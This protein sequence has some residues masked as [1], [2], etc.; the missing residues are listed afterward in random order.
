M[1]SS[2]TINPA[3]QARIMAAMRQLL[4]ELP[5]EVAAPPEV[6]FKH[7]GVQPTMP[8]YVTKDDF[9]QVTIYT[10]QATTGLTL[11]ARILTPDG[12]VSYMGESLDNVST[13]TL[14]QKI[15]GLTEGFL[16]SVSVSNINGGLADQIC[17]VSVGLQF[18]SHAS[19]APHTMLCQGYVS[20]LYTIDWPPVYV[21]GPASSSTQ[22]TGVTPWS[23]VA[24]ANPTIA[25]IGLTT[26]YNQAASFSAAN[27]AQGILLT[28]TTSAAGNHLE[29]IVEAYP[30]PPFTTTAV[31]SLPP[32]SSGAEIGVCVLASL[33]AKAMTMS[34]N[35]NN[36]N[37][38]S[39]DTWSTPTTH[40]SSLFAG[41]GFGASLAGFRVQDDS[42]NIKFWF[43]SDGLVWTL[44]YS[45][46]K[47]AS[48]LGTGNFNYLGAYIDPQTGSATSAIVAWASTSP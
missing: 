34:V 5:R 15:F 23:T 39:S 27:I 12:R 16:L 19:T 3:Q 7:F 35:W 18:S 33:T 22:T 43:S 29:G 42:T 26:A 17:F 37:A 11:T 14:T 10:T 21:R 32:N 9:L 1:G 4:E 24:G 38:P 45:V 2:T 40:N 13:S 20:N 48:Y 41:G 30:T 44:V 28:D 6:H 8:A 36:P 31:M 25:G 46:A 47:S